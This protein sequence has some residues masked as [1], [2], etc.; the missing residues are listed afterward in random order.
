MRK[1]EKS[2][3][4]LINRIDDELIWWLLV[5]NPSGDHTNGS[6]KAQKSDPALP[7]MGRVL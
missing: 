2:E 3:E 6:G 4:N 5:K 7:D 1:R